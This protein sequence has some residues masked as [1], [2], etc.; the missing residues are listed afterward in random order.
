MLS[1]VTSKGQITIPKDIRTL[2]N[3]RTNDKVDFVIEGNRAVLVPVRSL[4]ELRGAVQSAGKSD[5]IEERATAKKAVAK[6]VREEMS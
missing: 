4:R 3:I 6:R 2:L 5:F 1:T